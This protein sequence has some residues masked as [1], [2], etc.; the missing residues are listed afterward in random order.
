MAVSF[1]Q[2]IR[3][4]FTGINIAHM[5]SFCVA[6]DDS[7]Y[8]RAPGKLTAQEAHIARLAGEELPNWEIAVVL[9]LSPQAVEWAPRQDLHQARGHHPAA[10][11]AV[12]CVGSP[13][14][15]APPQAA[16]NT[17]GPLVSRPV[18]RHAPRVVTARPSALASPSFRPG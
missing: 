12:R 8:R 1:T 3:P 4:L 17:E 15:P 18:T 11:A 16:L 10:V 13:Y 6:L 7:G 2:D 5:K 9:Y 14:L